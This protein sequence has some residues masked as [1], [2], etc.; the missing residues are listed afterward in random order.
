MK[1]KQWFQRGWVKF[2]FLG[3]FFAVG[4]LIMVFG[5]NSPAYGNTQRLNQLERQMDRL[6]KDFQQ[7]YRELLANT[8]RAIQNQQQGC[9]QGTTS[10]KKGFWQKMNTPPE[11]YRSR[12]PN[13]PKRAW[14]E[15][16]K[17]Q[18]RIRQENSR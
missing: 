4:F 5:F 12:Y 8:E 10:G 1:K 15:Y 16:H 7:Q 14:K 17:E 2:R 6:L 18:E 11:P 13:N 9:E 3:A